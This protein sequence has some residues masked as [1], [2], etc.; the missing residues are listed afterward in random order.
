MQTLSI[1]EFCKQQNFVEVAKSTRKNSNDYGFI[2]FI[3][4]D[5]EATN[6]YFSKSLDAEIE[7]NTPIKRGFFA[8]KV[9]VITENAEG[10]SRYKISHKD[11][12]RLSIE[13]IL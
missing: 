1:S 11:S 4:S 12:Q 2:T 8:D 9:I 7:E 10:E 13:D 3:N 6:I 5:N